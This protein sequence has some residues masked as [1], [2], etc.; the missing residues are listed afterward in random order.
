MRPKGLLDRALDAVGLGREQ[1][2]LAP[3]SSVRFP[4]LSLDADRSYTLYLNEQP[5][6]C[7][8]TPALMDRMLAELETFIQAAEQA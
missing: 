7:A 5:N 8:W 1:P 3:R 4:R 6:P 2:L